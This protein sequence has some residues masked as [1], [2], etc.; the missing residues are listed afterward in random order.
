MTDC[1]ALVHLPLLPLMLA[2]AGMPAQLQFRVHIT[3][4]EL[5]K[6]PAQGWNDGL[7]G[8]ATPSPIICHAGE[9]WNASPAAS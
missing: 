9:R 4:P 8:I 7:F 6:I 2:N 5:S 1:S 3:K